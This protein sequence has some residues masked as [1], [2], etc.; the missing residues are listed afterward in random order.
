MSR[1]YRA[2]DV[3]TE[4]AVALKILRN[5]A[6]DPAYRERFLLEAQSMAKLKSR[7]TTRL[8]HF[9]RDFT[10]GILYIA[11]ELADGDD[12]EHLLSWGRVKLPLALDILEQTSMALKEAHEKA[13][14]HRDLK[15]ANIRLV[16]QNGK[17]C[18]K[19]LDFGFARMQDEMSKDR[20]TG[21]GMIP[22]TLTYVSPEELELREVDW[23]VD[24]Y[25]LGV[26]AFE[27]LTGRAPFQGKTPQLTAVMHLTEAPPKLDSLIE[28]PALLVELIDMMMRKA[29]EDRIQ[30]SSEVIEVVQEIRTSAGLE[31]FTPNH[32]GVSE[33]PFKDWDLARFN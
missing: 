15:P 24:I 8:F 23:R 25:T 33:S 11:M 10:Q 20:L 13:I 31:H 2:V 18:V 6:P 19:L 28:S 1:V 17:L 7:H 27:M 12:L 4:R 9:G 29:P 30:H 14:I 21:H 32:T 16:P 5:D 3:Y 22:G 26:V